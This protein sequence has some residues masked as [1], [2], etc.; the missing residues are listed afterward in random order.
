MEE[1]STFVA[2]GSISDL[3]NFFYAGS[4]K[5]FIGQSL[6]SYSVGFMATHPDAANN[7]V[8]DGLVGSPTLIST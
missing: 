4:S 8:P 5:K 1:A 6:L 3:S 2:G 7:W